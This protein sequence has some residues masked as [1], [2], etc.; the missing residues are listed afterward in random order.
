MTRDIAPLSADEF[1]WCSKTSGLAGSE[2]EEA[3]LKHEA[4]QP[5]CNTND[6]NKALSTGRSAVVSG[7]NRRAASFI[8]ALQHF[9]PSSSR[10]GIAP[11]RTSEAMVSSEGLLWRM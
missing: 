2:S 11:M 9:E 5:H 1:A 8:S 4:G 10:R 6:L 7:Q 3:V